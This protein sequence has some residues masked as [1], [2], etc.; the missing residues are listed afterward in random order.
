[1][2]YDPRDSQWLLR[3]AGLALNAASLGK[4]KTFRNSHTMEYNRIIYFEETK[5]S[6][7]M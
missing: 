2:Q 7:E 1:M 6:F 3:K 5:D 4:Q